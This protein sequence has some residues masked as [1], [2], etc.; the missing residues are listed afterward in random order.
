VSTATTTTTTTKPTTTTTKPATTAATTAGTTDQQVSFYVSFSNL[1]VTDKDVMKA[2]FE[3]VVTFLVNAAGLTSNQVSVTNAEVMPCGAPA[4]RRLVDTA[5]IIFKIVVKA[6]T[7][8]NGQKLKSFLSASSAVSSLVSI[9][10]NNNVESFT[11]LTT[12]DV[13]I[14]DV[15]TGVQQNICSAEFGQWTTCSLDGHPKDGI[16]EHS[17]GCGVGYKKQ[18]VVD[19]SYDE[20]DN[21]CTANDTADKF[22][23]CGITEDLSKQ[24]SQEVGAVEINHWLLSGQMILKGIIRTTDVTLEMVGVF[25]NSANWDV[26]GSNMKIDNLSETDDGI[27]IHWSVIVPNTAFSKINMA[28]FHTDAEVSL[29]AAFKKIDTMKGLSVEHFGIVSAKEGEEVDQSSIV[30]FLKGSSS[31]VVPALAL[32]LLSFILSFM[33]V[34]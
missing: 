32:P 13:K 14:C 10:E 4:G 30:D 25:L 26:A 6:L 19:G 22:K 9:V 2:D 17:Y 20:T 16:A 8:A 5:P 21:L 12:D 11:L 3:T 23:I 33:F 15:K 31:A 24:C 34:Y 1:P 28:T 18:S 27:S 7:V 29:N